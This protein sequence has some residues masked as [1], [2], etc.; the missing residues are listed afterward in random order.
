MNFGE[1]LRSLR[2]KNNLTQ[3][4]LASI[5]NVSHSNISK[6]EAG[7]L[8]PNLAFINKAS[9]YFKV[10][11]DYLLGNSNIPNPDNPQLQEANEL[12][13]VDPDL[14]IELCRAKDLPEEERRRIKEFAAFEIEKFLKSKRNKDNGNKSK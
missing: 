10:S 2:E 14:L 3:K 13:K 12:M 8:E 4:D 9:K 1:R 7:S 6:Y 5:L 11:I